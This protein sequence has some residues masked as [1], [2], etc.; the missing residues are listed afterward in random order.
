MRHIE[1]SEMPT[2]NTKRDSSDLTVNVGGRVL[3][4]TSDATPLE[5]IHLAIAIASITLGADPSDYLV[6]HDIDKYF[7]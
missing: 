4:P 3:V 7:V 5:A 6:K 2:I 1:T